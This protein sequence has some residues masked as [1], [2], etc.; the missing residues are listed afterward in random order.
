MEDGIPVPKSWL[1]IPDGA[2]VN[3][4][5]R[6]LF[7][8]HRGLWDEDTEDVLKSDAIEPY[9]EFV[10]WEAKQKYNDP[11]IQQVAL[12]FKA[13]VCTIKD[14]DAPTNTGMTSDRNVPIHWLDGGWQNR[15]TLI[16]FSNSGF[17][18]EIGSTANSAHT[19]P[20]TPPTSTAQPW[21][22][23]GATPMEPRTRTT[24]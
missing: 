17:Y 21:S 3:D 19:S 16:A 22:G 18:S 2:Q 12:Q 6:L 8:T 14:V 10:Q 4:Q 11:I 5:F 23:P 13:V 24:P 15:P 9:N 7:V 1:H 20:G